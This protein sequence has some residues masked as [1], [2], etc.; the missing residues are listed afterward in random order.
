MSSEPTINLLK[1]MLVFKGVNDD[2]IQE[3]KI[4]QVILGGVSFPLL[5]SDLVSV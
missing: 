2:V 3:P 5:S 1:N 4:I